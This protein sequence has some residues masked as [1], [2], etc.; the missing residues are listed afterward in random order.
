MTEDDVVFELIV[1]RASKGSNDN[2]GDVNMKMTRVY[3]P[4]NETT[5]NHNQ[6][7][8]KKNAN[9]VIEKDDRPCETIG[10][11]MTMHSSIAA[12]ILRGNRTT[13][14]SNHPG[15][16]TFATT[17]GNTAAKSVEDESF[18][19]FVTRMK[20]HG[21]DDPEVRPRDTALVS[22]M[23]PRDEAPT[24]DSVAAG[25]SLQDG[26][27][28]RPYNLEGA[29]SKEYDADHDDLRWKRLKPS[30]NRNDPT[31]RGGYDY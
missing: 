13:H 2:D 11:F 1:K 8:S 16:N 10:S 27:M 6:A 3:C 19:R 21:N 26:R 20:R 25:L 29:S 18:T 17:P 5:A 15:D 12:N 30:P 9:A 24:N 4:T 28:K 14:P 23:R 31:T 7:S 22:P